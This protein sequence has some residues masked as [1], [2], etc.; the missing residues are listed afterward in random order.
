MTV[1]IDRHRLYDAR[2][3]W[4]RVAGSRWR[5]ARWTKK[6]CK[7]ALRLP[8][9]ERAALAQTLLSSLD[10]PSDSE[11]EQTWLSEAVRRARELDRG[12]V[13]AIPAQDV[14][15]KALSLLR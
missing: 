11:L 14:R 8:A 10:E 1:A 3:D 13:Q 7:A 5:G 4:T 12:E 6:P 9:D 15:R 2:Q